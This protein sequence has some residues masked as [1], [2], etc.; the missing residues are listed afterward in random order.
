MAN[1]TGPDRSR[2]VRSTFARVAGRYDLMNRLMSAGQDG[3]WRRRAIRLADLRPGARLLDLGAGTGD[4]TAEALRRRPGLSVVAADFTLE[5]MRLGRQRP[6]RGSIPWL[7]ADA[8]CLPF[9]E[10]TFDAAV[11]GFLMRNVADV[12]RALWEQQRVLK[13]GGRIVILET[14]PPP[15]GVFSPLARFYLRRV[16]PLLGR[17]VAGQPAAYAYLSASTEGFLPAEALAD[18]MAAAGFRQV[19]FE[20]RMA[21]AVAIHWGVK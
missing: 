14:T 12:P 17:L 8:L 11:S 5:M 16:I 6:G 7:A 4:L 13:P 18:C 10:A 9:A 21:G 1:L 2:Y 19:R 20:R 15:R 3:A